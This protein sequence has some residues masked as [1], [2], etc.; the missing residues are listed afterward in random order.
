MPSTFPTT[1]ATF[2]AIPASPSP[3]RH[4]VS[5]MTDQSPAV[6]LG[7]PPATLLRVV[8]PMVGFLLR[9]PLAGPLR[10]QMMVVNVTGRKSGRKYS[11]PLSA[12][13]IDGT[14]YALTS[15]PWKNNFR[16]GATAEVLHAGKTTTMRGELISDPAVV[17]ELSERCA[18]AY[19]AKKAQT[20]MGLKF[21]DDRIPTVEE[22]REV[23]ERENMIAVKFTA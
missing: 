15:A 13:Q 14:L 23:A 10:K 20:M 6:T 1:S 17:A 19:G 21:R 22:F 3:I 4:T 2:N 11:I 8:N 5:A 16:G 18:T 7:H 12:H 9:T